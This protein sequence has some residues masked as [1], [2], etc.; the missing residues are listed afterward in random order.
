[1]NPLDLCGRKENPWVVEWVFADTVELLW[2]TSV[3]EKLEYLRKVDDSPNDWLIISL[4]FANWNYHFFKLIPQ[5]ATLISFHKFKI[6]F[7]FFFTNFC[8]FLMLIPHQPRSCRLR[9]ALPSAD[10]RHPRRWAVGRCSSQW[11][12]RRDSSAPTYSWYDSIGSSRTL[13]RLR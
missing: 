13:L 5:N 7:K 8:H 9:S 3:A 4:W 1:M 12:N 6:L 2:L 11:T 10:G